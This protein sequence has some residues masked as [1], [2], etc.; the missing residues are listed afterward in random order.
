MFVMPARRPES[1]SIRS[2]RVRSLT[3]MRTV[4]RSLSRSRNVLL[5]RLTDTTVPSYS[6]A[7]A[8]EAAG[9]A[10]AGAA[11]TAAV[12][13]ASGMMVRD[14]R[15]EHLRWERRGLAPLSR[16]PGKRTASARQRFGKAPRP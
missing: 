7:A 5:S 16:M 13:R 14:K 9:A 8:L 4:P 10:A 12:T 15:M 6:R 11:A 3:R 1:P 2:K